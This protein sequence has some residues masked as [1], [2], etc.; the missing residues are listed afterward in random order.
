MIEWTEGQREN[1]ETV[2]VLVLLADLHHVELGL[3]VLEVLQR[4]EHIV[5]LGWS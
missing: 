3:N 2:F 4:V 5:P 1:V